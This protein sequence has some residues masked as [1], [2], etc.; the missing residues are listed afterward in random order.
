[1]SPV[2]IPQKLDWNDAGQPVPSASMK[3]VMEAT[4]TLHK[5]M[6]QTL[7][8][9]QVEAV[10][11]EIGVGLANK[12]TPAYSA[13]PLSALTN[14]VK[15]RCACVVVSVLVCAFVFAALC[16][17]VL[18]CVCSRVRACARLPKCVSVCV[19]ARRLAADVRHLLMTLRRCHGLRKEGG[20]VDAPVSRPPP[21][22]EHQAMLE[23]AQFTLDSVEAWV[24]RHF[25]G[26]VG[27]ATPAPTPTHSVSP[28]PD[29]EPRAAST[30]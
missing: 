7:D 18:L 29:T 2:C 9:E 5:L 20:E 4:S 21:T 26:I 27:Q 15:D 17:S 10:F 24:N 16:V 22:L 8:E 30:A 23:S 12:L 13:V 14:V 11:C 28:T 6:Q 1:M 3:K 25:Y 19:C